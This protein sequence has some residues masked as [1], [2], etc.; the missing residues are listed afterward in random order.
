MNSDKDNNINMAAVHA[1]VESGLTKLERDPVRG[2]RNMLDMGRLFSRTHRQRS[3]FQMAQRMLGRRRSQYMQLVKRAVAN[4]ERDT[5]KTVGINLGYHSWSQ[6]AKVIRAVEEQRGFNVPWS[7]V[8]RLNQDCGQ[9]LSADE[10]RDAVAQA[11]ELGVHCYWLAIDERRGDLD[12]LM[13]ICGTF[14]DCAFIIMLPV[15]MVDEGMAQ[16]ALEQRNIVICVGG[17]RS[18]ELKRATDV[19]HQAKLLYGLYRLYDDTDYQNITGGEMLSTTDMYGGQFAVFMH[20]PDCSEECRAKVHAY[21]NGEKDA[22]ER[23]VFM[24][25]FFAD[26]ATVDNIISSQPCY[27]EIESDGEIR[28]SPRQEP[29]GV[30]LRTHTV[31]NAMMEL[32]PRS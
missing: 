20:A 29:S 27:I 7:F 3:F 31:A 23:P 28:P 26:L 25:D 16:H 13:D 32:V 14:A 24:V 6:G 2:V 12:E 15:G 5:L 9:P 22:P 1:A 17:E 19:L 11:R 18:D 10:V 4:V 8:I 21:A 30:N